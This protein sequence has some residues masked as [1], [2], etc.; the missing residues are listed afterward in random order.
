MRLLL[1]GIELLKFCLDLLPTLLELISGLLDVSLACNSFA[2]TYVP[3]YDTLGPN[4]VEFIINHA[5]VSIAFVQENKIAS[6]LSCLGRCSSNLKTIVSFGNVSAAQKKEAEEFGASCFSWEEF[7]QLVQE[8]AQNGQVELEKHVITKTLTKPS[9]AYYDA[10]NLPHVL[11]FHEIRLPSLKFISLFRALCVMEEILN[12][13]I[14]HSG[15]FVSEDLSVY[16]GGEIADLRV[17]ADMWGYFELLDAIKELGYPAIEKIYYKDPTAGMNLLFDDKGAL[18]IADLYMVHLR[19]EVFIQHPL[20]QP[21]YVDESEVI[22][23]EISLNV[24]EDDAVRQNEV[25]EDAEDV[26]IQKEAIEDVVGQKEASEDVVIQNEASED[27]VGQKEASENAVGQNDDDSSDDDS[28]DD[29]R[30]S[31]DSAK[32][33]VFDDETDDCDTDLEE[34]EG[35]AE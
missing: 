2:V 6:I 29:S 19:V 35:M 16:E 34:E 17:D 26:V 4:A 30:F 7:L 18:E 15:Q 24:M 8:E 31:Y 1:F 23:D 28:S 21:E 32:E 3:L 9:E 14:H 13:T 12:I 10:K 20:S 25:S 11:G 5:E 27:D 22:L 33:V